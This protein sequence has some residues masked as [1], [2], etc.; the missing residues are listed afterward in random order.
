VLLSVLALLAAGP[1]FHLGPAT[2][3]AKDVD[4]RP[5]GHGLWLHLTYVD[6]QRELSTNGLLAE[7]SAGSV[8]IDTGWTQAQ[9]ERLLDW[10]EHV[11]HRPVVLAVVTHAHRDRMGGAGAAL[12]RGIPVRALAATQALARAAALPIPNEVIE[13]PASLVVGEER[14]EVFFPGPGHTRDNAVV[15]L[16]RFGLLYGGCFLKSADASDLGNL[17]DADVSSWPKSLESLTTR[18]P[19]PAWVVPG[20][21]SLGGDPLART[22]ELLVAYRAKHPQR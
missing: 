6:D 1:S 19:K 21:G 9:G 20:H 18:Y 12:S 5:L 2:S 3:L 11:L 14:F 16:P 17:A 7:T 8:L 22:R 4:V 13:P 10:A 15:Y